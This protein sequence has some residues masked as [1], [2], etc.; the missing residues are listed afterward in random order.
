MKSI[1]LRI[2]SWT[3]LDTKKGEVKLVLSEKSNVPSQRGGSGLR[4]A[5]K[6]YAYCKLDAMNDKRQAISNKG[7]SFS[8]MTT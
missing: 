4:F 6:A 2:K 5:W 3:P 8:H 1:S 7:F